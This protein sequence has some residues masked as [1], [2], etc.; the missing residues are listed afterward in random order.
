MDH[1]CAQ[2]GFRPHLL[3]QSVMHPERHGITP[4]AAR[5]P[6]WL[7][8]SGSTHGGRPVR[9]LHGGITAALVP[10]HLVATLAASEFLE[11]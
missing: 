6:P 5:L 9:T 2:A 7:P 10:G 8:F 11:R 1:P 3:C 4:A